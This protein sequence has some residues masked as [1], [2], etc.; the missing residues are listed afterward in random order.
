MSKLINFFNDFDLITTP[1]K[2]NQI[3]IKQFVFAYPTNCIFY[4]NNP[5][6]KLTL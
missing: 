2:G 4:I 5:I 1:I 3:F 6:K